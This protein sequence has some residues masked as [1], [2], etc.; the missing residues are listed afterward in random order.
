MTIRLYGLAKGNGSWPRVTAGVRIG[1]A[2]HGALAGFYDVGQVDAA[3]DA[4]DGNA[5]DEGYDAKTGICVGAPPSASVMVGRGQHQERWLLIAT[6]SSWLPESMMERAR[7][8]VTGFLAPSRWSASVI[9][10]YVGEAPVRVYQHG[11]DDS[12]K[13][14]RT[15]PNLLG[16]P[17]TVLHLAS[18]HMERKGTGELIEGWASAMRRGD[19]PRSAKLRLVVDGPRGYFS[20]HIKKASDLQ[21]IRDSY[22]LEGRVSL[23]VENMAAF[24]RTHHVVCQPSRGEGFGLVPLEARACGVSVIATACTGHEE[25]V[26]EGLPGVVVVPHGP[27]ALVD[28]GPGATAPMVDPEAIAAALGYC[29]ACYDSI[30]SQAYAAAPFVRS[31]WSWAAV[32]RSFLSG[33][34]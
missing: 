17:F 4:D 24:Y 21:F 12:F 33:M 26:R 3:Y 14:S 29:H 19:L 7:K 31:E 32:T 34:V 27:E 2:H 25:H 9:K 11:V 22:L 23:S 6:N 10:K 8:V 16:G 13:A 1:L 30:A 28:D 18:T 15:M 20:S 5:L